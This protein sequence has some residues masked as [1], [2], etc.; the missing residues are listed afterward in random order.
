MCRL[1]LL[2]VQNTR[3]AYELKLHQL[4]EHLESACSVHQISILF[5]H[6]QVDS[7]DYANPPTGLPVV[8]EMYKHIRCTLLIAIYIHLED[9]LDKLE[10]NIL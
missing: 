1:L 8:A 10:I 9:A 4:S 6:Y 3:V 7:S 5:F 2:F